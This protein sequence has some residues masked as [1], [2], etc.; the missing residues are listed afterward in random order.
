MAARATSMPPPGSLRPT[1]A[2]QAGTC[3]HVRDWCCRFFGTIFRN[4]SRAPP[5]PASCL[6]CFDR[7]A[8]VAVHRRRGCGDPVCV[9]ITARRYVHGFTL[10]VRAADL[11]G[12]VRRVA[13]LDTVRISERIVAHSAQRQIDTRPRLRA[14]RDG[15]SDRAARLRAAPGWHRRAAPGRARAQAGRSQRDSGHTGNPRALTLRD[16]AGPDRS[17]RRSRG[18]AGDGIRPGADRPNRTDGHQLQRWAG[19]RGGRTAV[20]AKSSARM[21]SPSAVTTTCGACWSISAREWSR[22]ARSGSAGA[23]CHEAMRPPHDY[24]VAIVLLTVAEH[25]VPPEQLAPLREAVRRF[26]GRRISTESTSHRQN[27]SSRPCASSR[28]RCPSRPRRC[29]SM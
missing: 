15:T 9:G 6:P 7:H 21:S 28:E 27:A 1:L 22:R 26:C 25:L 20:A 24:G 13:D 3:R 17:D 18:V 2:D 23:R 5:D 12:P 8:T 19:H 29:S 16:H 11:H 14:D 10:V 4:W